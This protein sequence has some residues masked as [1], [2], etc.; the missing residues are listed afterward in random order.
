[1]KYYKN[2][3][4]NEVF[5]FE[6]DGSQDNLIISDMVQMTQA[7]ID[8]HINPPKT[9]AQ[10]AQEAK[11]AKINQ[12]TKITVT[13]TSGKVFDGDEVA[14]DRMARAV[15]FSQP[16]STTQWKLADNTIVI[17][18]REELVEAGLLAGQAMTT[19][20]MA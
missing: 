14:Q 11:Q 15:S 5:A 16:L 1:M 13:T 4:T 3:I 6:L 9:P 17:V 20:W 8:A 7:E 10:L 12:V 19:I 18:T 2:T